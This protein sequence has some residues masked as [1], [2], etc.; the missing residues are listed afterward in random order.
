M[1]TF[2]ALGRLAA[3]RALISTF[4]GAVLPQDRVT[5][6]ERDRPF[7]PPQGLRAFIAELCQ[8][9]GLSG[10]SPAI[11]PPAVQSFMDFWLARQLTASFGQV[12]IEF[13]FATDQPG[14]GAMLYGDNRRM[15]AS[16]REWANIGGVDHA[17][18]ER[19]TALCDTFSP[20]DL[21][22]VRAEF[23]PGAPARTS[24]ASSWFLDPF[25]RTARR[26]FAQRMA[27]LPKA[28]RSASLEARARAVE[29]AVMPDYQPL[30]LGLSFNDR[31]DGMLESKIY[32]VRYSQQPPLTDTCRLTALVRDLGIDAQALQ[33]VR[34]AYQG[35][36][37]AS[38]EPMSQF[39][40]SVPADDEQP[41]RINL[42]T[43][44]TRTGAV[45]DLLAERAWPTQRL[46]DFEQALET[47]RAK[48]IALGVTRAGLS[49]RTKL[50][51]HASFS[52][53]TWMTE[54]K[55][56]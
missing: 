53:R 15:N 10:S 46:D 51:G 50:Y 37:S 27:E 28:L 19:A 38:C 5:Y 13:S 35:L 4:P 47:G 54:P 14:F 18:A 33:D 22:M 42:I 7:Q 49:P 24:L 26:G 43:C 41:L 21:T 45:R 12:L 34:Q 29:Q 44:G 8:R 56:C 17:L 39:M 48:Y 40:A 31:K 6:Y 32:F 2:Q 20:N 3:R 1:S 23:M 55:A 16:F 30:F 11:V 9:Q 52:L 25:R 36:W